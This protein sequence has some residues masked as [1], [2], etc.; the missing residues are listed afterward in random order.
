MGRG[1][2][3]DV[4]IWALMFKFKK[5]KRAERKRQKFVMFFDVGKTD[6][7]SYT[8]GLCFSLTD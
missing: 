4:L 2:G 1:G 5:T 8:F 7:K 6:E 3:R